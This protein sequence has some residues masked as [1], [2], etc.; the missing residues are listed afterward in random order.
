MNREFPSPI[1]CPVERIPK[2]E[3]YID[4]YRDFDAFKETKSTGTMMCYCQR[5][6]SMYLPWTL[7]GANF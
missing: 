3:A 4:M 7:V 6:T 1:G 5:E 2:E